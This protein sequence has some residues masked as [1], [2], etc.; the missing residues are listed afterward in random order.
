MLGSAIGGF[1]L[2]VDRESTQTDQV[3]H[4]R[5]ELR[6]EVAELRLART[7]CT[8]AATIVYD[9]YV[10]LRAEAIGG[11]LPN[12]PADEAEVAVERA[13]EA[14]QECFGR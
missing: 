10:L 11:A 1:S 9:G 4:R 12:S 3:E 5:S 2:G 7:A 6:D 14:N 8:E 13:Y